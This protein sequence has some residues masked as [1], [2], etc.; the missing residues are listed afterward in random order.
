MN[1]SNKWLESA[2]L[3][4]AIGGS[5]CA[6][7]YF[8]AAIFFHQV[9]GLVEWLTNPTVITNISPAYFLS[10]G[11]AN[12]VSLLGVAGMKR[13]QR[14]GFRLYVL[15]QLLILLLPT[16]KMG[17]SSFSSVNAIF[18]LLFITIYAFNYRYFNR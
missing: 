15:A 1:K 6:L 5:F 9:A 13:A 4:S 12:C 16:L 7:L 8:C 11:G 10:L 18:T 2:L 3:L 14:S 17:L